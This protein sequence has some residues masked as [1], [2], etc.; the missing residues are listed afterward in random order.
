VI[1]EMNVCIV[2]GSLYYLLVI[3]ILVR[4]KRKERVG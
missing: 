1:K 2:E 4:R 3:H